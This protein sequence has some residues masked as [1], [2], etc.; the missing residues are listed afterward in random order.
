MWDKYLFIKEIRIVDVSIIP[1][2]ASIKSKIFL[3]G[4]IVETVS[5]RMSEYPIVKKVIPEK[6]MYSTISLISVNK[7]ENH[8]YFLNSCFWFKRRFTSTKGI[9]F[10]NNAANKGGTLMQRLFLILIVLAISFGTT[11]ASFVDN[12]GGLIYDTD[13]NITWCDSPSTVVDWYH[14]VPDPNQQI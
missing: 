11:Q 12:G 7:E 14:R 1:I 9:S 13:Q 2:P 8:Y 6:N 5:F 4:S 3:I 10:I